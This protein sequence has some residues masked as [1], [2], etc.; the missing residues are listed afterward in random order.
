MQD[1]IKRSETV[2]HIGK[3]ENVVGMTIECSG[4]KASIGDINT[5]SSDNGT[6]QVMAEVVGFKNDRIILMPYENISGLSAGDFVRN[7]NMRLKIPVGDFLQGRIVDSM[8][9][10]IDGRGSFDHI[11]ERYFVEST[12]VNPLT[13]PPIRERMDFGIKVI[14][15][16]LSIGKGQRI[17]IFAGSGVGKSTLMG[18]IAKNVRADINVIALVGERGREVREFLEEDL[19]EEGLRRSVLVVATS[20]QPAMLRMKCP[21]VATA[22]AEYFKDQGK[23]VLL[24]MDSL[25]RFAMAQ[26]EIGLA[27]GE[28]PV[29]RGYTPSIYAEMPKLLERSGNF[30]QGSITGVYTVLVEG[31][32]TNEPI[33]DT[34][35]GILDGHIVLSRKLA[36]RNHYP[37]ID[38]NSSVSRLMNLIVSQEHLD[39]Q[40]AIRDILSEYNENADLISIG[41]YKPGL[42]P[43]L[44]HAVKKIDSVNAFLKQGTA[45]NFSYDETVGMMKSLLK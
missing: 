15:G 45:E 40:G 34:V 28:P 23:D 41:A 22:I 5:I 11:E 25:T 20:D 10:P 35:R 8:G 26:R 3:I 9:N 29:A 32:D 43:R 19:G 4:S 30:E 6:R 39:T 12:I 7:T 16:T 31:D 27:V 42:N 18:M 17:G 37:A 14:D 1:L 2:S 33:S 44:D 36:H 21:L 13:R 24:M 38:V